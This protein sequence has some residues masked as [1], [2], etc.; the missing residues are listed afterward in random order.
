MLWHKTAPTRARIGL[1][2]DLIAAV[3]ATAAPVIDLLARLSLSRAFFEPGMM[4]GA[5]GLPGWIAI[6]QV[7][8]PLLLALGWFVRP[9]ALLL[10]A[11]TLLHQASV[12][13]DGEALL[14]A[15][16]LGWYLVQGAGPLSLDHLFDKGLGF[17]PLPFAGSAMSAAHWTRRVL[18]PVYRLAVR[19]W[20]AASLFGLAGLMVPG[21]TW[22]HLPA[23][24]AALAGLL[25]LLGLATPLVCLLLIVV[26]ASMMVAH[27]MMGHPMA[28][29]FITLPPLLGLLGSQGAGRWSLDWLINA[30][31]HR[32][33]ML[34]ADAPHIVIVGAGFGGIACAEGLRHANA[35]VTLIDR[36]NHHLFQPLLYQVATGALSPADIATPIRTLFRDDPNIT[37]LCAT[38]SAI[39]TTA[40][41]VIASGRSIAYDAI[42]LATGATHGYFGKDHWAAHAPGLKSVADA[43][44]IRSRILEAFERSE[45]CQDKAELSALLTFVVVGA[46]PT[47]VEL[48]GAIAELARHGMAKD[49]RNFDPAEARILLIQAAPRVLPTFTED[50]SAFS[51][52]ALRNLGVEVMLDTAVQDVNASGVLINGAWLPAATVVWAAGVMASPA[53]TWLGVTADRAGRVP[54]GPD[55]LV[56]GLSDVF[57]IGDTAAMTDGKGMPVPGLAPAAKQGGAYVAKVL[58]ARLAGRPAPGPFAYRHQGS[59]ATI[60]RKSAVADFGGLKLKGALAWWLWGAVHVLFLGSLRSRASVVIGWVWSYFTFD[61]GVRL[62]TSPHER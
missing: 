2:L 30:W 16:L 14:Q 57:V 10:L 27:L 36:Q 20:L 60:G 17:S 37:V 7:G 22:S 38:V 33:A 58:R 44:A 46:G 42:V 34:G 19:L 23:L 49:F 47:G 13:L 45:A 15:V 24:P 41:Q 40:R 3:L 51:L 5:L 12:G 32:K 48:A 29:M 55:L 9:V 62:I 59:L 21:D 39:D 52:A 31:A 4:T 53:A 61:V 18:A 35:R 54:V 28:G 11:L 26:P 25:L 6:L 8:G 1:G 50:L 56:P 43:T